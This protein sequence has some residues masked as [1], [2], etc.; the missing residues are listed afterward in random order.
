MPPAT[1]ATPRTAIETVAVPVTGRPPPPEPAPDDPETDTPGDP[2][3]DV[4]GDSESEGA[5]VG[6]SVPPPPAGQVWVRLNFSAVPVT[7]AV[8][9]VRV[10]PAGVMIQALLVP[11][12]VTM[13]PPSVGMVSEP[14]APKTAVTETKSPTLS[15]S[16]GRTKTHTSLSAKGPPPKSQPWSS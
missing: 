2:G 16:P 8:A 11:L 12:S 7:T 15:C 9:P 5:G 6:D 3:V 1:R 10:H 13:S 4:V 14:F